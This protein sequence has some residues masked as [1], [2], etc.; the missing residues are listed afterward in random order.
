MIWASY[1]LQCIRRGWTKTTAMA[2]GSRRAG[3]KHVRRVYLLSPLPAF[4]VPLFLPVCLVPGELTVPVLA[5][6]VMCLCD[7]S[8][9]VLTR[10]EPVSRVVCW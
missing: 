6:Y 8:L 1:S 4:L 10:K 5:W 3:V 9:K 2:Q 7:L